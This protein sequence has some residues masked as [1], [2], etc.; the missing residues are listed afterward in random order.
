MRAPPKRG[1]R[2]RAPEMNDSPARSSATSNADVA[3]RVAATIRPEIRALTAYHVVKAERMI[4]LD[5]M[6]NPYALPA[7]VRAR[8]G[9]ALA[10]V[11]INRYPDGAADTVKRAL[12]ASLSLPDEVA[13]IVGNGSDEV[14]QLITT[15]V[16]RPGAA[17]VAPDP[18]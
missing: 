2:R 5:A 11:E 14:L 7:D 18:S 13:L 17:V 9:S 12:R 15:A 6:E 4:K 16:A 3:A 8:L 1:C 10:D